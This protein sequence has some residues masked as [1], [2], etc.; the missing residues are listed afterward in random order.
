M[1]AAPAS[2]SERFC[3]TN[4]RLSDKN[5][6]RSHLAPIWR[7]EKSAPKNCCRKFRK[8]SMTGPEAGSFPGA[9]LQPS[10]TKKKPAERTGADWG[11]HKTR[12]AKDDYIL[13]HEQNLSLS[14]DETQ[15]SKPGFLHAFYKSFMES[16][17]QAG[18]PLISSA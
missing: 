5:T 9:I 6:A 15:Y 13:H 4:R 12:N 14:K 3:R 17:W 1:G 10:G 7:W 18:T 2:Q 11:G 16:I 8:F